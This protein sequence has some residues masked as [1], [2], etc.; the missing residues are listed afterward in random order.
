MSPREEH[1]HLVLVNQMIKLAGRD[2]PLD[3]TLT[4][5]DGRGST[6]TRIIT[7][8]IVKGALNFRI[9]VFLEGAQ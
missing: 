8:R 5:S 1:L 6:E 4:F 7:I 9:K 3:V 2:D